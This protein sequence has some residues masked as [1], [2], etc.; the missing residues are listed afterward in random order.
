M[1]KKVKQLPLEVTTSILPTNT[2]NFILSTSREYSIYVCQSRGIP[3]ISDG[4]KDS[5]RKG[6][7]V[8]SSI[9]D[10]I[11]TISLSGLCISRNI[12]LHGDVSASDMLSLMAA[13]YC[14]NMPLL[15]GIGAFGNLVGPTDWAAP[16]YTYLKKYKATEALVYIDSD[17]IP[18]KENYDG[19]VMEPKYYLP[20]IPLV[21]LNGVSGI[22]VGWSTEILPH[23]LS[24]IISAT[25]AAI[26]GK[27]WDPLIPNY[28]Y[29]NCDVKTL[30][31]NSW[32]FTGKCNIDG[33]IVWITELPPKINLENF[34]VKLN[35]LED[36]NLI[37]TYTDHSADTIKIEVRFKRG[38]LQGI[39][40]GE[41]T[42][43]PWTEA[44]A[45]AFFGLKTKC[46]QRLVT[47]DWSGDS[48]RQF[49]NTT[50]LIT[51][52]V[53]W[54]IKFYAIRYQKIID[55]LNYQRNFYLAIKACYDGNLPSWLPKALNKI[56]VKNKV[57]LLTKNIALI[58][59][60][61]D[62]IVGLPTYRWAQDAYQEVCNKI[63]DLATEIA[64]N[65]SILADPKK[66]RKIYRQ[67]VENLRK[68]PAIER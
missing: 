41:Q 39:T 48:I 66:M 54:R 37:Q 16:R 50:E 33:N 47:L 26:D 38:F 40:D 18:M 12:Y 30:A 17:I 52:F 63:A 2:S 9:S 4:L 29:L 32:E 14:N 23:K 3:C 49:A 42:H 53:E 28:E 24:D 64:I 56:D 44:D 51:E 10:K 20:L 15:Q 62:R 5:Q 34:K 57:I 7:F 45:V 19:S 13:P 31:E 11:K 61:Y 35:K 68:L 55:D 59:E 46:S 65:E 25:I 36:E 67:E 43:N 60:Q 21:L 22:A 27:P 8:I 1:A 58:D 6:L